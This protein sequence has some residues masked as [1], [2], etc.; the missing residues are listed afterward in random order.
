MYMGEPAGFGLMTLL[1]TAAFTKALGTRNSFTSGPQDC[2]NKFWAAG[3]IY[4]H[5][6]IHPIPDLDSCDLAVIIGMNP[7]VSKGSFM[8][9]PDAMQRIRAIEKRG[10]RVW[11]VDPR[12]SESVRTCGRHLPIRPGTDIALLTWLIHE[13]SAT[14]GWAAAI[15][16]TPSLGDLKNALPSLPLEL[17]ERITGLDR[18]SLQAL[19]TDFLKARSPILHMSVGVNF[20]PFGSLAYVLLHAAML[21]LGNVDRPGGW[22]YHPLGLRMGRWGPILGIGVQ[23]QKSRI[24]GYVPVMDSLPG[25]ILADEILTSGDDRIRALVVIA[26]NP[27]WSI[28]DETR[29]RQAFRSLDLL[30]VIDLFRSQTAEMAHAVL[31]GR[32]W[33]ERADF[34]TLGMVIQ[35]REWLSYSK[36][37][38]PPAGESKS[39]WEI[40]YRILA[41]MKVGGPVKTFL[42]RRLARLDHDRWLVRAQGLLSRLLDRKGKGR[43]RAIKVSA[44]TH[45]GRPSRASQHG[46]HTLH[47]FTP[48]LQAEVER[49]RKWLDRPRVEESKSEPKNEWIPLSMIGRR[50]PLMYNSWH[51]ARTAGRARSAMDGRGG[52]GSEGPGGGDGSALLH[53]STVSALGLM[54]GRPIELRRDGSGA[55]SL[56]WESS[57]D[58]LSGVVSVPH[59][60][61]EANMN[62]LIPSGSAAIEPSS[63][64]HIMTA[65]PVSAR[66]VRA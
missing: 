15:R 49:L 7:M 44:P 65:I 16:E 34:A 42:H 19:R 47:L 36:P 18:D 55:V 2:N 46:D 43:G 6:A 53:P 52:C 14:Q 66:R 32:T 31:P 29:L 39:E 48:V 28:P 1:A 58:V 26:G 38:L 3:E 56:R 17:A 5:G 60:L 20:G 51:G 35:N 40:L 13:L 57:E 8:F 12:R 63:G 25:G 4:G 54:V 9:L 64:Q 11:W 62:R 10:G 23:T 59:G 61:A 33:L 24:G 45:E 27:I 30:V 21:A 37:V 41:E 50:R 22:L